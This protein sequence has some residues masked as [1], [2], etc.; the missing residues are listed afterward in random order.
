MGSNFHN[1]VFVTYGTYSAKELFDICYSS[2]K[3]VYTNTKLV[4]YCLDQ[5]LFDYCKDKDVIR[6]LHDEIQPTSY[7]YWN[8]DLDSNYQKINRQKFKIINKA[9]LIY[10]DFIYIDLDTV[11]ISSVLDY[12]ASLTSGFYSSVYCNNTFCAGVMYLKQVGHDTIK[13][14]MST[15]YDDEKLLTHFFYTKK[16]DIRKLDKEIVANADFGTVPPLCG[17][18]HYPGVADLKLKI[19]LLNNAALLKS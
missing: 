10:E 17:I 2:F 4:I 15:D 13:T 19:K 5:Q 16:L 14:L 3:H 11:H 8:L 7:E 6:F 18:L 9:S 1:L 12:L